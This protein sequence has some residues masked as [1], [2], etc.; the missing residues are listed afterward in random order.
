MLHQ[1]RPA[2]PVTTARLVPLE[3]LGSKESPDSKVHRVLL[4]SQAIQVR[5]ANPVKLVQLVPMDYRV[6]P[7]VV[8]TAHRRERHRATDLQRAIE[9]SMYSHPI[10]DRIDS[11]PAQF[12]LSLIAVC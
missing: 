6:R 3:A 12:R 4:A 9:V 5:L 2:D 8:I 10:C 1:A 7:A 11:I